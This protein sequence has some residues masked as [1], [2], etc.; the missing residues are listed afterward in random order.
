MKLTD[1]C[2]VPFEYSEDYCANGKA[3]LR[4]RQFSLAA[5]AIRNIQASLTNS[6]ALC[7]APIPLGSNNPVA[8]KAGP[9]QASGVDPAHGGAE[10]LPFASNSTCL[11][12]RRPLGLL[13]AGTRLAGPCSLTG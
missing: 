2:P 5:A 7:V 1:S 4:Y 11:E 6:M 12:T 13:K 10:P 9:G 3:S 8:P